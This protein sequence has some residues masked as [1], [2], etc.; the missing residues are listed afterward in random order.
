[1]SKPKGE[2]DSIRNGI[3]VTVVGGLI[4]AA[5]LAFPEWFKTSW[6][7]IVAT[8]HFLFASIPVPRFV[9]GLLVLFCLV[10]AYR[11]IRRAVQKVLNVP[12]IDDSF[13]YTKDEIFGLVWRWDYSTSNPLERLRAF[14]PRCDTI[15]VHSLDFVSRNYQSWTTFSCETCKK[16]VTTLEGDINHVLQKVGRQI[17][18]KVRTGEW[19]Q[20]IKS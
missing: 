12:S 16:E 10:M 15:L 1:M 4:L 5:I 7:V 13:L 6:K 9:L 14:C 11:E 3:I 18:R 17:E 19:K 8:W 20:A 2:R